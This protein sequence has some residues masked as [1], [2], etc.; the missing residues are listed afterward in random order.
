MS[1]VNQPG[2]SPSALERA[3]QALAGLTRLVPDFP[4]P[5]VLFR[6][7]S[8]AL[9]DSATLVLLGAATAELTGEVEL[10]AAIEAR[11]FLLGTSAAL[12][13]G[14]GVVPLRKPGKLPGTGTDAVLT[15]S[16]AL[17]YGTA[18]LELQP[19]DIPAGARVA[20]VDDVL[21]TGGTAA[22]A[23]DLVRSAGGE[24]VAVVVGVEIL[25]LGGRARIPDDVP[26]HALQSVG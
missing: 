6:D 23:V 8:P 19:Q 2:P 3:G 25:A 13:A 18:A 24:V 9:A 5:G 7:L 11:G 1:G 26:V 20:V 10:V 14:A 4:T 21:A 22:A 17:E 16:Y 15:R 12:A